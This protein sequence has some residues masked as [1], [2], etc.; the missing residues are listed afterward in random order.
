MSPDELARELEDLKRYAPPPSDPVALLKRDNRICDL[1]QENLE[2]KQ[3]ATGRDA[4][5]DLLSLEANRQKRTLATLQIAHDSLLR[6][7]KIHEA[8]LRL[9]NQSWS[10][11]ALEERAAKRAFYLKSVCWI[12]VAVAS[13]TLSYAAIETTAKRWSYSHDDHLRML[14]QATEEHRQATQTW[15]EA[16]RLFERAA[17]LQKQSRHPKPSPALPAAGEQTEPTAEPK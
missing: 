13:V 3:A 11:S 2:L 5:I 14:R 8:E 15:K 9:H 10:R 7:Q 6:E 16:Q 1:E 12:A 17:R 4:R